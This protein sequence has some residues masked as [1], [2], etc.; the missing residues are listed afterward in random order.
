MRS[1]TLHSGTVAVLI[2][3]AVMLVMMTPDRAIAQENP[4]GTL[5]VSPQRADVGDT[6]AVLGFEIFP[7][8]QEVM[9]EY[10]A[11]LA[12]DGEPCGTS[13]LSPPSS[14][15]RST[16]SIAMEMTA[17]AAG[18]TAVRLVAADT[19]FVIDEREIIIS[20]PPDGVIG[21][22]EATPTIALKSI[23]SALNL[24]QSDR[25]E[26]EAR[27]LT[28]PNIDYSIN[29]AFRNA[30]SL[31]F[32]SGCRTFSKEE[33]ASSSSY[34]KW[35]TMNAC[36]APGTNVWAWVEEDGVAGP[37]TGL[38]N[39]WVTVRPLV[40]FEDDEYNVDEGDDVEITVELVG[41]TD[42]DPDIPIRISGGDYD[43]DGLN[44]DN[45]LEIGRFDTEESFTLEIEDDCDDDD[46]EI[47]LRFGTLPDSVASGDITSAKVYVDDDDSRDTCGG[48]PDPPDDP[49]VY[50][51]Q[52]SYEVDE[53][54]SVSLKVSVT[55][56]G[57]TSTVRIPIKWDSTAN[58][59][60]YTVGGLDNNRLVI[61]RGARFKF[62]RFTANDDNDCRDE[63]INF[64]FGDMPPGIDKGN[65]SSTYVVIDDPDTGCPTG[66]PVVTVSGPSAVTEGTVI[67]FTVKAS[68]APSSGSIR[69]P[70]TFKTKGN[71][72][73]YNPTSAVNLL[74]GETLKT[75]D[76][77]TM[78][79]EIDEPNGS[80]SV[81][82]GSGN[83]YSLGNE[84]TA[85]TSILDNDLP[86]VS[87]SASPSAGVIEG[88]TITFTVSADNAVNEDVTVNLT[89]MPDG[90]F[91]RAGTLPPTS[92][93]ID[94]G[95]TS[96]D[97]FAVETINDSNDEDDGSIAVSITSNSSLY[98]RG[99][100]SVKVPVYDDDTSK[101]TLS[102]EADETSITEGQTIR[103]TVTASPQATTSLSVRGTLANRS[104]TYYTSGFGTINANRSS[105]SFT[106]TPPDD[107]VDEV[108]DFIRATLTAHSAYRINSASSSVSVT[109]L[110]NDPTKI[111]FGA[112]SYSAVEGG[113]RA[114]VR[115]RLTT[116]ATSRL[117][118]PLVF[119]GSSDYSTSLTNNRVVINSGHSSAS[120]TVTATGDSDCNTE[121]VDIH[122]GSSLPG[123][124]QTGSPSSTEI[125]LAD[126]STCIVRPGK[127]S[128]V[129]YTPS[130]TTKGTVHLD[131]TLGA[132]AHGHTVQQCKPH[133]RFTTCRWEDVVVG[134][135][136]TANT[137]QVTGLDP[138]DEHQFRIRAFRGSYSAYSD[139]ITVDLKP[140][141]QTLAAT[142]TPGQYG[143]L[144]LTWDAVLNSDATY[145]VDQKGPGVIRLWRG[146]TP[147]ITQQGN[148]L[149][150]VVMDLEPGETY[151]Y[152]VR[153][154]TV[155]GESDWSEKAS[156]FVQDERPPRPRNLDT[157]YLVG[158]RGIELSWDND[159]TGMTTSY[160]VETEP[161]DSFIKISSVST[162]RTQ[163]TT[164]ITGLSTAR[165]KIKVYGVNAAG[166]S[167]DPG[168]IFENGPQ[169]T[170][171]KGHQ[172]DHVVKYDKS[173]VTNAEVR[174]ALDNAA[175]AWN[176][177][178]N[179]GLRV[180]DDSAISCHGRNTDGGV[181]TV[182]IFSTSP[183]DTHAGCKGWA[184]ACVSHGT[185]SGPPE[186]MVGRPRHNMDLKI[187]DPAYT[188]PGG[189]KSCG[190]AA[191]RHV[192]TDTQGQQGTP[193]YAGPVQ[194]GVFAYLRPVAMHEFGHSFGLS[195][196][197]TSRN[198]VNW[199][200]R[201]LN[202]TAIMRSPHG[203]MTIQVDQDIAQLDAIYA[204][205]TPH[206]P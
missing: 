71:M 205:H 85:T 24:G 187:E 72:L 45:E 159:S 188:C 123:G 46:D 70:I 89:N 114:T 175:K 73:R 26:V 186:D 178:T 77:G 68:P 5:V 171:G 105:T 60:D 74:Q 206:T 148:Q 107:M 168:L 41:S 144:T 65:P 137:V 9:I 81:T 117:T 163:S 78:D 145:M 22:A 191:T 96:A 203:A 174:M 180:C 169:P 94:D 139:S 138:D 158:F 151:D 49:E 167:K 190:T 201:L 193:A 160:E 143:Q 154:V 113:S 54:S 197:Y 170:Y 129:D 122:F 192:W 177:V 125:E 25:F 121:Y 182:K 106:V 172:A 58:D 157:D 18:Q 98:R 183:S 150:A 29:V 142:Y 115:V 80:I 165:Y 166:R 90:N 179:Y 61:N 155:H 82:V 202:V 55:E 120:F 164:T 97:S 12:P 161:T 76:V 152:R 53:G 63:R 130:T 6:V 92:V 7:P 99:T 4:T 119:S 86:R 31:A 196:F 91:F 30:S 14:T 16:G 128:G 62:F 11:H 3:L 21:Q 13:T 146:I 38:F 79:D 23:K 8:D 84:T 64:T 47:T 181:V 110:D 127:P 141:P 69:V 32:E 36:K 189:D 95:D 34:D 33:D 10:P 93:T 198:A 44:S 156:G 176:A 28:D 87:I 59:N 199:D 57:P 132:R 20:L 133:P 103:F 111:R 153:S 118:I 56:S 100:S 83:G 2:L 51:G 19:G 194:I 37:N 27:D 204:R 1:S 17:C 131:W 66:Q 124:L 35:Y 15:P 185:F 39:N 140:V 116:P 126:T 112:S 200:P 149:Q 109:V 102:I 162:G 42:Q 173:G 40:T 184:R 108:T 134:L 50:W 135:G 75:F 195:E 43:V 136:G 48:P 104:G 147:T 52:Q 101:P 67:E 88:N